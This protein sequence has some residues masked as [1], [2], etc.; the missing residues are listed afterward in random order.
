MTVG[1][2]DVTNGVDTADGVLTLEEAAALLKVSPDEL[3]KAAA[4][5][6]LPGRLLGAEWRFSRAA[7]LGWL[8]GHK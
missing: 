6:E 8:A 3:R 7:L 2:I 4:A 5:G 1:R